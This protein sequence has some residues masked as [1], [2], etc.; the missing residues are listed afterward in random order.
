[1]SNDNYVYELEQA[2]TKLLEFFEPDDSGHWRYVVYEDDEPLARL[3][4]D[5]ADAVDHANT[6]L[7][8]DELGQTD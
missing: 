5:L 4:G 2:L 8:G 3:D 1:M 6:I 7:Y